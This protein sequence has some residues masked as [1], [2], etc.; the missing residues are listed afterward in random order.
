LATL[1]TAGSV[2]EELYLSVLSRPPLAAETETVSTYLAQN[3]KHREGALADLA[4]ALLTS[5]EFRFNH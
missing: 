2:A 1:T 5:T 4:W 3:D